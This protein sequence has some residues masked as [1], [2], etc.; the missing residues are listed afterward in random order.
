MRRRRAAAQ[1]PEAT[2]FKEHASTRGGMEL[3]RTLAIAVPLLVAGLAGCL[4]DGDDEPADPLAALPTASGLI[5]VAPDPEM[6][7]GT[8][9]NDHATGAVGHLGHQLA[10]LHASGHNLDLLG[11]NDLSKDLMTP[12]GGFTE[13][14]VVGDLAVVSS[15][16]SQRGVTLL[17]VSD[18]SN[19]VVLSHIYNL[20]DNWDARISED[21]RFL[22]VGCQGSQAFDCTGVD[23]S[24]E[25]PEM[26]GGGVCK[27]AVA[28]SSPVDCPGGIAVYDIQNPEVP[29]FVF[30]LEMGFTHNVFTFTKDGLYYFVNARGS[31]GEFNPE[32]GTFEQASSE[33][34]GVHDIAVQK[35]PLTGDWLLY[36]GAGQFMSIWNVNDPFMP[37]LIG[38]VE[39][40]PAMWHEQTPMPCLI[41]GRHITI[42][43]GEK[44]GGEPEAVAVVDT[45]HPTRPKFLGQWTIPDFDSLTEQRNYRFSLHNV[46]GNC[47][48]QV[49]VGHYHA[50]VWVFDISTPERM[51][52]PVTL[53]YYQ[54]HERPVSQGW[55][56]LVT[57]PIG[58]L[59]SLDTP[60]VWTA[61][62]GR[63]GTLFVP[64][65]TTGLYALK[66][67]WEFEN[68]ASS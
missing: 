24:G 17:N 13:V 23:Q 29:K 33:I 39:E 60:N 31:I 61:Q 3:L 45:T 42:G 11:F 28:Q 14:H 1:P 55:S 16:T 12:S 15:L 46:D 27:P 18:P 48:G 58:A 8:I 7:L 2:S 65:M 19:M 37:E 64:D 9:A 10:E 21:G 38:S 57:A 34:Q 59:V 67:T 26:T 62:W 4:S 68:A 56:P 5:P 54:P 6:F 20:D 32:A 30:Y 66:P 35:H 47:D 41:A 51:M 40:G 63:D 49:A 43:A 50:G 25:Q 22:F 44:G 53:G 52:N 36:T